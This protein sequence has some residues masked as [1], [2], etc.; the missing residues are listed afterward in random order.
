MRNTDRRVDGDQ[1]VP[2]HRSGSAFRRQLLISK[3]A[4]SYP[5]WAVWRIS[6]IHAKCETES[7][8]A[9]TLDNP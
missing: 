9:N 4:G 1:I 8:Q 3:R 6:A 7:V 5:L 2:D